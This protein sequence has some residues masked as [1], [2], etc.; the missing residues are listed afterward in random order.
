MANA[1]RVKDTTATTGTGNITLSGTPPTGFRPLAD[2]GT[3]GA[4]FTYV[5]EGLTAGEWEVG[6]GTITATNQFSRAP[7]ASSNA[8]AAVSLTSG[9][10]F[11]VIPTATAQKDFAEK[12]T[13]KRIKPRITALSSSAT[14]TFNTDNC[15]RV[16]ITGLA[17]A[18]TGWTITGA[19]DAGDTLAIEITDNGTARVLAWSASFEPSTINMPTTTVAG[20]KLTVYFEYNATS[21]KWRCVGYA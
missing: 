9:A 18:I 16:H 21:S 12:L 5:L 15:D 20:Q 8:G 17:V 4:Q 6:V 1:E 2:C 3:I 19:P 10:T 11:A 7:T 13:N 14:P